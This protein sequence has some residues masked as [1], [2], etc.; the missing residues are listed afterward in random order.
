MISVVTPSTVLHEMFVTF[1]RDYLL[2]TERDD[3]DVSDDTINT[4]WS[5]TVTML[6]SRESVVIGPC[7]VVDSEGVFIFGSLCA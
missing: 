1:D 3:V 7:S 4:V 6:Q 5:S 2:Q